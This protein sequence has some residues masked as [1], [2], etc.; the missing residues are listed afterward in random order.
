M[1]ASG[2]IYRV[3]V[4]IDYSKVRREGSSALLV[5]PQGPPTGLSPGGCGDTPPPPP[6]G[7]PPPPLPPLLRESREGPRLM[8]SAGLE[9]WSC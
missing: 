6:P 1:A 5:P 3:L 7:A 8:G 9:L 2:E 4:P